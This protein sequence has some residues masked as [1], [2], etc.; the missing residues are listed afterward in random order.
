MN[1]FSIFFIMALS[2]CQNISLN[3][4]IDS[5]IDK[6]ILLR[7]SIVN[8]FC[9]DS[10]ITSMDYKEKYS[11]H[12]T[13]GKNGEESSFIFSDPLS[14]IREDKFKSLSTIIDMIKKDDNES[15]LSPKSIDM[16]GY[17]TTEI[18]YR[19]GCV[20]NGKAKIRKLYVRQLY[21]NKTITQ[22]V[23]CNLPIND[24]DDFQTKVR[25]KT[26][27][28]YGK[29]ITYTVSDLNSFDNYLSWLDEAETTL[30]SNKRIQLDGV[31]KFSCN[32]STYNLL[33]TAKINKIATYAALDCPK[34]GF[35]NFRMTDSN[36]QFECKK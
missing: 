29:E 13:C 25:K 16:I 6:E 1:K 3:N 11:I 35:K 22:V 5:K 4:D 20:I 31:Y 10:A 12:V 2:G 18:G 27:N 28:T 9:G 26:L 33:P 8:N 34:K 36:Y 32:D 15:L 23:S 17:Y 19:M 21:S 7:E 24:N 14:L 30:C